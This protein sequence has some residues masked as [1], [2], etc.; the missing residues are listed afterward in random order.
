MLT[1]RVHEVADRHRV[2][3]AGLNGI[4]AEDS[5][6]VRFRADAEV[7][8]AETSHL[9]IEVE[10]FLNSKALISSCP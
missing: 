6:L 4:I 8:L 9:C 10:G 1:L 2:V 7:L 3:P 5:L